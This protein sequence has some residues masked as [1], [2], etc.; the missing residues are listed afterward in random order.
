MKKVVCTII[1]LFSIFIGVKVFAEEEVTIPAVSLQEED[2]ELTCVYNDGVEITV[3]KYGVYLENYSTEQSSQN[4]SNSINFYLGNAENTYDA[5]GN[6]IEYNSYKVLSNGRCP[7]KLY[8]YSESEEIQ[9]GIDEDGDPEYDDI[10]SY[11]YTTKANVNAERKDV[12]RCFCGDV[13][14]PDVEGVIDWLEGF[15]L[16]DYFDAG[17]EL[18]PFTTCLQY[19]DCPQGNMNAKKVNKEVIEYYYFPNGR[20]VIS[21]K[22]ESAYLTSNKVTKI[23]D[24]ETTSEVA[25]STVQSASLYL[26]E[27]ISFL[28]MGG[29]ITPL[30]KT[31]TECPYMP[32][33]DSDGKEKTPAADVY[34][35]DPSPKPIGDS[36]ANLKYNS[37]RFAMYDNAKSCKNANGN[38]ECIK[39]K[40]IGTR[41]GD[42]N[43]SADQEVCRFIGNRT[44]ELIRDIVS[45]LRILVPALV[46]VLIGLDITK[47]VLAGNLEEELPK[48]KKSIIIR[49]IIMLVFFFLPLFVVLIIKL[50]NLSPDINIGDVSCLFLQ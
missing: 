36:Y 38:N 44:A 19:Y 9:V 24:Y 39:V 2:Y 10:Y 18:N 41:N 16:Y 33:Y 23:C 46:I 37:I 29:R 43:I 1:L 25:T 47:M 35:N 8:A 30:N 20:D 42:G 7:K 50:I 5:E 15:S 28:E 22:S 12:Y 6:V 45:W 4:T 40:Y 14:Q 13:E 32:T 26:Y 17:Y 31:Y 34:I 11:Y 49:L 21:L 3:S 27:N 48:K